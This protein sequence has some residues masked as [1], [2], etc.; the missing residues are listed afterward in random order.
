M[1]DIIISAKNDYKNL[2]KL[3]VVLVLAAQ[4]NLNIK[5]KQQKTL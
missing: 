1:D 2:K 3:K 5:K 4:Y